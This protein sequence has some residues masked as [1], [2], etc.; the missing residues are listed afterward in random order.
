MPPSNV[1]SARAPGKPPAPRRPLPA[2]LAA[3][4]GRHWARLARGAALAAGLSFCGWTAA[5]ELPAAPFLAVDDV[6]VHGNDLLPAG[7]VL[8]LMPGLRGAGILSVD[9]EEHRRRLAASPWL[10]GAAL[11]RRLPSTVDVFVAERRPVAVARFGGRLFLLDASG[12]VLDGYGPRFARF[13]FPIVD[14]LA[15]ERPGAAAVD[16]RRLALAARLLGELAGRPGVLEAVSQ[17]DVADPRDAVVLL[18]GDVVLLRLGAERFLPKLRRYA[19]L[20]PL[21]RGEALDVDEVDLRF[22]PRVY[23]RYADRP[24][25]ARRGRPGRIAG[26]PAGGPG[27]APASRR[28]EP[29]VVPRAAPNAAGPSRR[30]PGT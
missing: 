25:P 27:G 7:E 28:R 14:G 16:P 12:A 17:I 29:V 11:R 9:L 13:D 1:P 26:A 20:A 19:E 8:A 10:A 24:A 4:V 21:L 22:D 5:T 30:A 6:V 23:V 15:G 3:G 2:R 18:D